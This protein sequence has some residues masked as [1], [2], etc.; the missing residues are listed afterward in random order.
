MPALFCHEKRVDTHS[1]TLLGF[2]ARTTF[3]QNAKIFKVNHLLFVHDLKLFENNEDQIDSLMQT[4][5]WLSEDIGVEFGLKKCSLLVMK[6]TGKK[7]KV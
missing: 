5:Q 6:R 2:L 7:M 4:L 1:K 3:S